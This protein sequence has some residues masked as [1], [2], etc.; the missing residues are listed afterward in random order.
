[1]WR[2]ANAR[3]ATRGPPCALRH[4]SAA[5]A[6]AAVRDDLKLLSSMER[7]QRVT[8]VPSAL[9]AGGQQGEEGDEALPSMANGSRGGAR[10]AG[11]MRG[12]RCRDSAVA[13]RLGS[14]A[15]LDLLPRGVD[16]PD[17]ALRNVLLIRIVSRPPHVGRWPAG[18]ANRHVALG[19]TIF[20][21]FRWSRP[22]SSGARCHPTTQHTHERRTNQSLESSHAGSSPPAM[23]ERPTLKTTSP[24]RKQTQPLLPGIPSDSLASRGA[25]GTPASRRFNYARQQQHKQQQHKQ[26]QQQQD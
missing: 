9:H 12:S 1:M 25:A 19:R 17:A 8:F 22:S 21:P 4:P 15:R 20:K 23:H 2:A 3:R 13:G 24:T 7:G 26:Q 5:P 6:T 16:F 14:A 11:Q 10:R 18:F